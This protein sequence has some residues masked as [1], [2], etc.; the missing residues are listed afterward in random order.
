MTNKQRIGIFA[1]ALALLVTGFAAGRLGRATKVVEREKVVTK[2]VEA[3][4]SDTTEVSGAALSRDVRTDS[5]VRTVRVHRPD[6][7]RV[8]STTVRTRAAT[9]TKAA[10]TAVKVE[11]RIEYVDRERIVEKE[12]LTIREATRLMLG[13]QAS[14]GLDGR[15]GYGPMGSYRVLGPFEVVAAANVPGRSLMLGVGLRFW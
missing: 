9:E 13:A 6:G 12:K 2:E 14:M 3:K 1:A 8:D 11:T 10:T 4:R 15:F 7:T 5:E